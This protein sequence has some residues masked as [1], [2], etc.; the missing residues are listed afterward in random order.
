VEH[1]VTE[2]ITG[3][4]LVRE[5]VRIAAGESLGYRQEAIERRGAAIECRIYAEDPSTGFLPSPG[6]ITTLR[7][8]SGPGVRDDSGAYEGATI[9]ANY[10]PLI[11]KLCAWAPNRA[12]A[13]ARMRR[14]LA[15][16]VVG[17][18][19]TNLSF[20]ER[21]FEHPE[22]TAGE[23][24]TGFIERNQET[25]LGGRRLDDDERSRLAAAV[26]VAAFRAQ[27]VSANGVTKSVREGLS[28]WVAA[29]RAQLGRGR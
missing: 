25:L 13:V 9:S 11:S 7:T 4:D 10:D 26:A 6:T 28:P 5:M 24:D 19:K 14:A 21:L 16:Y 15:E 12:L 18:I 27:A 29:H 3:F 22:F 20:H 8:P 1:P 2:L 17:G 23:Y